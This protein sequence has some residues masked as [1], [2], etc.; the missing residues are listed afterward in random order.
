[1]KH[2][3]RF[4]LIL[5]LFGSCQQE[6]PVKNE[7]TS[8]SISPEAASGQVLKIKTAGV[9]LRASPGIEGDVLA[10]LP[11]QSIVYDQGKVSPFLTTI[12]VKGQEYSAPWVQVQTPQGDSGWI[13]ASPAA[14][15]TSNGPSFF[16]EKRLQAAFDKTVF[17]LFM[18]YQQQK[19]SIRND[20]AFLT[21]FQKLKR[22]RTELQQAVNSNPAQT[23]YFW[24]SEVLPELVP[25]LDPSDQSLDLYIDYRFWLK[26]T[27]QT[28]ATTDD[29]FIELC[30]T[31]YPE[32]SIEYRFPAW[33]F[34]TSANNGHSLLGRG[35]HLEMFEQIDNLY[36]ISEVF[37]PELEI[38]K[39]ALVEDIVL[40]NTTF[41]EPA[42]LA[43]KELIAL[44]GNNYAFL[45]ESDHLALQKRLAD[46][47]E[48]EKN[49]LQFNL[50]AGGL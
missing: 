10:E 18:D 25:Q 13:F 12:R 46:F 29:Q 36:H 1:M 9:F 3:I 44:I 17:Q 40:L 21:A 15:T 28:K 37:Q 7:A 33:F 8:A 48:T 16:L 47:E 5:M 6:Q 49:G 4:F 27:K 42:A 34:Q 19:D 20:T 50:K 2:A 38:F 26:Q 14:I 24:I 41:W 23:D 31:A 22:L 45:D 39:Q 32:D 43:K 35:I 11:P 30:L